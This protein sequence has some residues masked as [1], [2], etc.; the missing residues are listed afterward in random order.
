M[1]KQK[2]AWSAVV[3]QM[4]FWMNPNWV[5]QKGQKKTIPVNGLAQE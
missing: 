4:S 5:K 1:K 2:Q 3:L